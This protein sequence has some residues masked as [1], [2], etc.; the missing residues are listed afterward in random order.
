MGRI[1]DLAEKLWTGA[2]PA[3]DHPPYAP[4]L[5]LEAIADGV[6]FL[7][8]FANVTA[9]AT[10]EGLVLVDV[11]CQP[12]AP[13]VFGQVR[14]WSKERVHT[15]IFT[16]GHLDHVMGIAQFDDEA[17]RGSKPL[18]RVVAHEGVPVRFERYKLTAGYNGCI[19]TRQFQ[20]PIAWPTSFRAP[21]VLYAKELT[22]D[23]GGVTIELHHARG[24]T[25]DHTW[26][27]VPAK[28][29]L[30]TGD[31][32]LW[33]C[34]N[35]GNPQKV[36]RYPREWAGALRA[37][38]ELG[39]EVL[40]PGHGVPIVGAARVKQALSETAELLEL[41]HDRTVEMMNAG[42]RLEDVVR[43]VRAPERL[44]GRPYLRPL[45]DEPEFI[46]RNVWRLYGGWWDGDPSR[47]KP[48]PREELANELATLAG[49][50]AKLAERAEALA[51]TGSAMDLAL[52]C[53]LV[54][55]AGDA[56]PRDAAIVKTRADVYFK[57]SRSE[58]SLMARG[59]YAA[60]ASE[61]PKRRG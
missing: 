42:A 4:L 29:L 41:L 6:A 40:A 15:A 3:E 56:A 26:A 2:V 33:C 52:A 10:G 43:A 25:D 28:K 13:M 37:M 23:V 32:F 44:I 18:P 27:W 21:D 39:A 60:A 19:N 14:E 17:L 50:P 7:S 45:Y 47:L 31:L 11:G 36:Q 53:H 51:G 61:P 57:R 5:E 46:V 1:L 55:I 38:A 22:L 58:G 34:P 20:M 16:H 9:I 8:S 12:L 24:E 35:A 30:C 59:I 48:A 54:E 49:G